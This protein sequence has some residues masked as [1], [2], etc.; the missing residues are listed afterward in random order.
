MKKKW[1]KLHLLHRS[2][3]HFLMGQKAYR[4]VS[5]IVIFDIFCP[6]LSLIC[7]VTVP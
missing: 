2:K 5:R 1:H 7:E 3:G 6:K 4:S